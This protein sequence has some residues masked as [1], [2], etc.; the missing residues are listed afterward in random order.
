MPRPEAT[1]GIPRN[2]EEKIGGPVF[3]KIA[4]ALQIV[5]YGRLSRWERKNDVA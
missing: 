1:E 2:A 5:L 3:W 4:G